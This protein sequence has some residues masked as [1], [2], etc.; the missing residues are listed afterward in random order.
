MTYLGID[1]FSI[2]FAV[3]LM[4]S[5]T[6]YTVVLRFPQRIT[7]TIY[8]NKNYVNMVSLFLKVSYCTE[9]IYFQT[10]FRQG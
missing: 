2:Y 6:L 3:C 9:L 8:C 5:F 7:V 4:N 1:L 10:A